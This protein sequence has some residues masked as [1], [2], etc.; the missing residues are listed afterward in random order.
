M[1]S[2]KKC[3]IGDI[4]KCLEYWRQIDA[5]LEGKYLS[6]ILPLKAFSYFACLPFD[7]SE[8]DAAREYLNVIQQTC[9]KRGYT[10]MKRIM[11]KTLPILESVNNAN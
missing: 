8:I 3:S 6:G 1:I 5:F 11:N 10:K 2:G 9:Q 7:A 4:Q